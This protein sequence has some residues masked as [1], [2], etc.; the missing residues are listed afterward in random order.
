MKALRRDR[1][2][3]DQP[4]DDDQRAAD[5]DLVLA[6]EPT[7]MRLESRAGH[8]AERVRRA[9][10]HRVVHA[11]DVA[12]RHEHVAVGTEPQDLVEVKARADLEHRGP[13]TRGFRADARA[14]PRAVSDRAVEL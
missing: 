11:V 6:Q 5:R 12:M 8:D 1:D 9:A 2:R 7:G 13:R 3:R 4:T 14:E 10:W